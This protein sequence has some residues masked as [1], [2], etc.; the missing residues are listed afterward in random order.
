VSVAG[1]SVTGMV[2]WQLTIDANDPVLLARFW[3]Q[4]LGYQPVPPAEPATTWHAHY[5]A[6]LGAEAAFDDRLFDPA[7]LRPPIW[8]QEVPETKAGKNRLHLDLYPTGRDNGLP[9]DRRIEIVEAKVAELVGLGASV[10]RRTR[11]DDPA[12]P[13][14]YVV[15]HDPEGNE[16][17]VS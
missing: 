10:E 7:G 13:V 15:M 2:F 3:A 14:Y 8:F 17:C 11:H 6:R 5:R 1:A 12:D 4:T 9:L 16:F